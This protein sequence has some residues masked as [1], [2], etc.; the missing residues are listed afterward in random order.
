MSSGANS[1]NDFEIEQIGRLTVLEALQSKRKLEPNTSGMTVSE[2]EQLT[3]RP[4][5]HL[6]F[7]TWERGILFRV[8]AN[9]F[10]YHMVR[11]LVGTAVAVARGRIE[12]G[13]LP[14]ILASCDRRRAGPTA[15]PDGLTLAQVLYPAHCAPLGEWVDGWG[16]DAG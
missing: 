15:P 14:A 5:E 11:N 1:E 13:A 7:T 12:A 6:E 8:H 3:G 10:L 16:R 9:R 2:L 4:R